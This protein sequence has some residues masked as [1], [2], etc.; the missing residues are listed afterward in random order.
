MKNMIKITDYCKNNIF[1]I[2]K[3][4]DELKQGKYKN[5]LSGK[6]IVMFFPNTSIRT[7][8][9]FEKG[10]YLLGG[11][12]IL[13]PTEALDKK[14]SLKDVC[15]YLNNWADMIIVRHKDIRL[16][17][18]LSAYAKIPVI[19]AMTDINHPCEIIADMYALSKIRKDF[20]NDKYLFCGEK[21][22]IGLAWKEASK[23]MGFELVQCCP[24]GYE[25][26][27]L[28]TSNNLLEAIKNKDIICVDS[29]PKSLLKDFKNFQI[30]K[31][32]MAM[33]NKDAI[34]N[35]CPPFY[36]GEEISE[37]VI[38]SKYFVGYEFKKYLLEVQ[39]AI[40]VYCLT[41]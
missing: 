39:Q 37:S 2:F 4:A 36:R 18:E 31:D 6:T 10:I 5:I 9:T 13:F 26:E 16:I 29:I 20:I 38:D 28:V 7:R 12:A 1:E 27:G 22:N 30:T 33:A 8:V 34:L 23:V 11:Q 3:I 15:G 24:K 21:G 32:V 41:Q 40:I 19:N 17:K 14:E 35:P 25:M